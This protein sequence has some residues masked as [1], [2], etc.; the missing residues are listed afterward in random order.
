MPLFHSLIVIFFHSFSYTYVKGNNKTG[1]TKIMGTKKAK[2]IWKN[3][4]V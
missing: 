1:K 4:H 3:Y 2:I